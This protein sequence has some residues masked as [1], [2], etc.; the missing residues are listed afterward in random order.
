M[1]LGRPILR[2]RSLLALAA[3]LALAVPGTAAQGGPVSGGTLD[4]L[5]QY[6]IAPDDVAL[7]ERDGLLAFN[8]QFGR[9][10]V[11]LLD[12]GTPDEFQTAVALVA[13]GASG[14]EEETA[15]LRQAATDGAGLL[16]QAGI[17]G[18]GELGPRGGKELVGLL[19]VP[20]HP[21][22]V[23]LALLRSGNEL[24]RKVLLDR[25]RSSGADPAL[26]EL[27]DFVDAPGGFVQVPS[28]ARLLFELRFSAAR[29]YGLVD[30]Q[31]WGVHLL[32]ALAADDAFLDEVV[33]LAAAD[34]YDAA[35]R[36]FVLARLVEEGGP[37]PVAAA[38]R[39]MPDELR[40][41]VENDLWAP[42]GLAEWLVVMRELEH[43]GPEPADVPLLLLATEQ[44]AIELAA[45]RQL[46]ELGEVASAEF[47]RD[48]LSDSS[49]PIRAGAVRGLGGS[50]DKTWLTELERMKDDPDAAV[51]MSA[52]VA[53]VR[54]GSGS[55]LAKV[56]ELLNDPSGPDVPTLIQALALEVDD[57]LV[58]PLLQ[59]ARDRA[60]GDD[61]MVIDTALRSR[62]DL[63]VGRDLVKV[64]GMPS[65]LEGRAWI[66]TSLARNVDR[67]D[68]PFLEQVFPSEHFPG[69]NTDVAVAL[70]RSGSPE[71]T[72]LLRKAL[73]RGPFDRSQ[74]AAAALVDQ[75]GVRV[76]T[77]EL[78]SAP[79]ETST[80]ALRR[81]GYAI[82]IFGGIDELDRLR[83]RRGPGDP[84]LMGAYL[85]TL[86]SRTF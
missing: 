70:A 59:G 24:G 48:K 71:G 8:R 60:L 32:E 51:R 25:F 26:L 79:L 1:K 30:G 80:E 46:A 16:R 77:T 62:G 41:L 57:P 7:M 35:V 6:L 38:M 23:R 5:S 66:V 34:S 14:L 82:G 18:L 83:R 27:I 84:A 37:A 21:E 67:Q 40:A 42:E 55:A 2:V 4:Y 56:R 12:E 74:L 73:W 52:L 13:I 33:F 15:R 43:A 61:R 39:C 50:D 45:H 10:A 72:A 69:V 31:R 78:A 9:D 64:L 17:I 86:A 22:L 20:G 58:K 44:P 85:G 29:D 75:G 53:R 49:A 63:F 81:V 3:C 11:R 36:D 19:D 54:L 76:L 28:S 65:G 68:V 47:L